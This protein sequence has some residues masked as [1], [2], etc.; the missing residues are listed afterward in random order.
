MRIR[1]MLY[2]VKRI[3]MSGQAKSSASPVVSS[4]ISTCPALRAACIHEFAHLGIARCFGAA[5]FVSIAS[6][7]SRDAQH[8]G[9]HAC[10]QLHGTLSEDE[11]R[12]VALAG[13]IA[14][15]IDAGDP[16]MLDEVVAHVGTPGVLSHTDA[17][18]SRGYD[19]SHV[20]SCLSLLRAGWRD[21]EADAQAR[22][23]SVAANVEWLARSSSGL[24]SYAVDD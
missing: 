22:A 5:G 23:N 21:I 2:S 1:A 12:I 20:A 8:A 15:R 14:E 19:A 10:F 7:R 13:V 3:A 9:W 17:A 16:C 24:P 11:W 6:A 4:R 18:L